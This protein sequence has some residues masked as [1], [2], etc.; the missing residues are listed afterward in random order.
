MGDGVV[1]LVLQFGDGARGWLGVE[2]LFRVSWKRSSLP[3]SAG[4]TAARTGT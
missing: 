4:G 2:V 1:E 3:Q